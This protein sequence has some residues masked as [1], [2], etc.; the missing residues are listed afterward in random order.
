MHKAVSGNL[1]EL[2]AFHN[3]ALGV[4]YGHLAAGRQAGH[5]G[6][7]VIHHGNQVHLL[8]IV[9][10]GQGAEFTN[11][12]LVVHEFIYQSVLQKIFRK[13]QG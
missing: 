9:H 6:L 12:G 8:N 11:Q 10:L 13:Y 2:I 1:G 5:L 3:L 7:H 4:D